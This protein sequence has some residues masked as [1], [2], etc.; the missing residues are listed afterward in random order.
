MA[1][2]VEF[3]YVEVPPPRKRASSIRTAA[4]Y[5]SDDNN[6]NSQTSKASTSGHS[7][8]ALSLTTSQS[9]NNK[10]KER[11]RVNGEASSS[12]RNSR[13]PALLDQARPGPSSTTAR[14]EDPQSST[15]GTSV[16]SVPHQLNGSGLSAPTLKAT[17]S[18]SSSTASSGKQGDEGSGSPPTMARPKGHG[19]STRKK[20]K[21]VIH[22]SDESSGETV[23]VRAAPPRRKDR[24]VS[25]Q[26][27]Q[28]N[29]SISSKVFPETEDEVEYTSLGVDEEIAKVLGSKK[30]GSH[31][32]YAV[33]LKD[34]SK[35]FV[36]AF[37]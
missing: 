21:I 15:A 29:G 16:S 31:Y 37:P 5:D 10:G 8:T 28:T 36:G 11:E 4:N 18:S 32:A 13:S 7:K 34:R 6:N 35:V 3:L 1:R 33:K 20:R 24:Q 22:E 12:A 26:K 30:Y 23:A 25:S 27:Q 14:T 2:K 9:S 17:G 19:L